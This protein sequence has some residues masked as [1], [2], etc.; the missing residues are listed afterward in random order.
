MTADHDVLSGSRKVTVSVAA[1][2]QSTAPPKTAET[3][4]G[5][6]F[7]G[8]TGAA[9]R[10]VKS[11]PFV[12]PCPPLGVAVT[13]VSPVAAALLAV[14]WMVSTVLQSENETLAGSAVTPAGR[15]VSETEIGNA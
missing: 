14:S 5:A 10:S 1:T 9:T 15:P 12:V 13:S 7:V 4:V 2:R 6:A 8:A 3:L 11:A